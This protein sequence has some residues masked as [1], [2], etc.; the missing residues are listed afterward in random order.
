MRASRLVSILLLLQARGRLTATA[1]ATELEVSVRTIYRDVESLQEAGVPIY[2][3]AGPAGGYQLLDGYRTRLT[4][5]STAEAESLFLAGLPGPAAALGLGTVVAAAQLKLRAALP[6]EL[7]DRSGRIQE[8]FHLDAPGWYSDG[9]ATPFLLAVADAVWN[10]RRIQVRYRR[11]TAPTDVTRTLS[12]LGIV[13]KAGRWYVVAAIDAAVRTFRVDQI[14]DLSQLDEGFTRPPDFD[15]ATYWR[16]YLLE[17]RDRLLQGEAVVRFSPTGRQRVPDLL[18]GIVAA[19][20]DASA[21]PPDASGW[22]T[23][24]IPIESP[25]RAEVDMLRFGA[26]VEVLAPPELRERVA[27]TVKSLNALY[28]PP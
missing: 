13:L 17:F 11:W 26:D 18:S 1:L 5:L 28:A 22:V 2:G 7:R 3:D 20:V 12:P 16:G 19:A 14:L 23:A 10:E 25:T 4:G 8:R 24:T 6:G 15:L 21:G 27:G 9:D